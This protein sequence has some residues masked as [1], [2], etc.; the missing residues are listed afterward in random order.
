MLQSICQVNWNV[1]SWALDTNFYESIKKTQAHGEELQHQYHYNR[2][3]N[4]VE[5]VEKVLYLNF[6]GFKRIDNFFLNWGII[7]NC[8]NVN[9]LAKFFTIVACIVYCLHSAIIFIFH[10][11]MYFNL[12]YVFFYI[13]TILI[14]RYKLKTD[15]SFPHLSCQHNSSAQG[16]HIPL[17]REYHFSD[18]L[19]WSH[20]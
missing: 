18:S 4:W 9:L 2:W 1:N 19:Y 8:I 3:K 5:R 10:F 13:P 11:A 12:R 14:W 7:V 20:C 15:I 17:I 6:F 16:I